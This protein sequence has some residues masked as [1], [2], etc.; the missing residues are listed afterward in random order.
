MSVNHNGINAIRDG[1]AV[2]EPPAETP[3]DLIRRAAAM[4]R[5]RATAA[6]PGPWTAHLLPADEH[7]RHPA[8]WVKAEYPDGAAVSSEVVADCPWRQAD[9]DWIATMHP[10]VGP[11]LAAWL[12][13]AADALTGTDVPDNE[14]ALATARALLGEWADHA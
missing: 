11:A 2:W 13:Q 3:A 1:R 7:H 14:P 8:H 4:V 5:E 10:G 12:E 6:T 9:A